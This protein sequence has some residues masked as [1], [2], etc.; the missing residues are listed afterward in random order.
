MYS[1]H[2]EINNPNFLTH[3]RRIPDAS[4][5]QAGEQDSNDDVST[6]LAEDA[7]PAH[8]TT[9]PFSTTKVGSFQ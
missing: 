7:D 4:K 9:I 3:V 6:E 1:N 2:D 8:I 5:M